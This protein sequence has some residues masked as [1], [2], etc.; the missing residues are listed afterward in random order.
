[1]LLLGHP[2][3]CSTEFYHLWKTILG[4]TYRER[5]V[6]VIAKWTRTTLFRI[7]III[8]NNCWMNWCVF[9]RERMLACVYV[10]MY[11]L[12]CVRTCVCV[13]GFFVLRLVCACV[14]IYLPNPITTGRIWIQSFPSPWLVAVAQLKN[15]V[16]PSI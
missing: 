3:V 14:G 11:L 8:G 9:V 7:W 16:C 13:C 5:W 10:C 2:S 15:P 12:A 1:M 6:Y 4:L